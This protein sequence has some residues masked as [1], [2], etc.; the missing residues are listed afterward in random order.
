MAPTAEFFN[1]FQVPGAGFGLKQERTKSFV[2]G[3]V[4]SGSNIH[5]GALT[6]ICRN[7]TNNIDIGKRTDAANLNVSGRGDPKD[8]TCWA[9][10]FFPFCGPTTCSFRLFT[11]SPHGLQ[12][13][14]SSSF[15]LFL[16]PKHDIFH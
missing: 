7:K 4:A 6:K 15:F 5:E 16:R 8:T 13:P 9:K 3:L 10:A 1:L 14:I 2:P 12:H 11:T